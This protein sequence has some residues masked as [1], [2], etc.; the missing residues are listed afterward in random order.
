MT[1]SS[2]VSDSYI[3]VVNLSGGEFHLHQKLPAAFYML[4]CQ[5]LELSCKPQG[6]RNVRSDTRIAYRLYTAKD[7]GHVQFHSVSKLLICP[8]LLNV[9]IC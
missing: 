9:E 3:P 4:N 7:K 8:C 5:V 6:G 2:A 1:K